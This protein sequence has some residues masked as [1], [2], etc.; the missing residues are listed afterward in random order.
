MRVREGKGERGRRGER[1][2][3]REGERE[4]G[5]EGEGRGERG[6][7]GRGERGEGETHSV[8]LGQF[9]LDRFQ[10]KN[11]L[12]TGEDRMTRNQKI[13]AYCQLVCCQAEQFSQK[14]REASLN[15]SAWKIKCTEA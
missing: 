9:Y 11:K 15:Q 1:E 13:R 14:P 10:R 5:R 4:R 6:E 3:G 2:K 7:E 8:L 12:D